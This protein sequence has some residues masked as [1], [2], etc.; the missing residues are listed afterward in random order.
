GAGCYS[1]QVQIAGA[2]PIIRKDRYLS[3][4]NSWDRCRL[5]RNPLSLTLAG[6]AITEASTL[7]VLGVDL[8]SPGS[9]S[10]W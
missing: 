2:H 9:A 7:R 3:I 1:N 4:A 8:T 5:R 10:P 6:Q